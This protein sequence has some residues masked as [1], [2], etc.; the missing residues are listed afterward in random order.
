MHRNDLLEK[1]ATYPA[2]WPEERATTQKLI[3]FVEQHAGCFER[4]LAVGHVT[5]SAWV[6]NQAG[7]HVLLTHHKKLGKWLQ[8]GGHADG[9]SNILRTALREVREESGL[10][11]FEPVSTDIFDIDIHLIPKRKGNPA[12]YHYDIRFAIQVTGSE[13]YV[14]SDESHDLAW[15]E[16]KSL[17]QFTLEES[18]LRMAN[19]WLTGRISHQIEL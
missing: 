14:V 3:G 13:E 18:M 17:N 12:H 4:S 1:L 19:K 8:L 16:V 9:D 7:T 10:T 6:I 15:V 2:T 11:A 5:G